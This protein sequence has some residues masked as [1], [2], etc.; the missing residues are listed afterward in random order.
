MPRLPAAGCPGIS[1][2]LPSAFLMC[3]FFFLNLCFFCHAQMKTDFEIL[4]FFDDGKALFPAVPL[5]VLSVLNRRNTGDA[6][7]TLP[8]AYSRAG[9]HCG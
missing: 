9:Y 8:I 1:S 4:I 7:V 5:A 2:F 6:A 3:F